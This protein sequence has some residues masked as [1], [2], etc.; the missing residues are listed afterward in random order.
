MILTWPGFRS[1]IQFYSITCLVEAFCSYI[2]LT[3][4]IF[5]ITKLTMIIFQNQFCWFILF[6]M[7]FSSVVTTLQQVEKMKYYHLECGLIIMILS[8]MDTILC[9]A[10]KR[11]YCL[12]DINLILLNIHW[13]SFLT[14]AGR[15]Q[16][17][18]RFKWK[19]HC[20]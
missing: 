5:K 11:F 7:F 9:A 20:K 12:F 17:F 19:N 13:V 18:Q 15:I 10:A 4:H 6:L 14:V 1:L 8:S 16:R 2:S 3:R